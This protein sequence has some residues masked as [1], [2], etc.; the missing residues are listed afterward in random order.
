[1]IHNLLACV[2]WGKLILLCKPQFSHLKIGESNSIVATLLIGWT[3]IQNLGQMLRLN[4]HTHT[5]NMKK[6]ITPRMSHF[7]R[8]EQ[9]SHSA[10]KMA[11]EVKE[12]R[13]G[14]CIY[15]G[16][17]MGLGYRYL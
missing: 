7:G 17:L 5:E 2:I 8:V 15:G 11:L 16:E 12:R 13:L 14:W 3:F 10:P 9:A 4:T 6:F 1:M